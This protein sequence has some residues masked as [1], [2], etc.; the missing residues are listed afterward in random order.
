MRRRPRLPISTGNVGPPLPLLGQARDQIYDGPKSSRSRRRRPLIDGVNPRR[1]LPRDI[2]KPI[3]VDPSSQI[4][5][6]SQSPLA[7]FASASR[8]TPPQS[9]LTV[10]AWPNDQ[11]AGSPSVTLLY[12]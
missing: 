12:A 10:H 1:S 2:R 6:A 3:E 7:S 4:A 9:T 5:V 11:C 8:K